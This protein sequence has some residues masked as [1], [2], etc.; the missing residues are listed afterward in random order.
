V[1]HVKLCNAPPQVYHVLG[2]TGF[3]QNIPN[4]ES[5]QAALDSFGDRR[6]IPDRIHPAK[7]QTE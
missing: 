7:I 5:Q 3:L 1:A 6:A 2:I 4:F